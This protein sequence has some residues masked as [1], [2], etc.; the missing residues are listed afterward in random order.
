MKE[1]VFVSIVTL[2]FSGYCLGQESLSLQQCRDLAIKNN[3]E[4]KESADQ[5]IIADQNRKAAFTKYFPNVSANGVYIWNQKDLDLI[6]YGALGI[7]GDIIPQGVRDMTSLDIQNIWIGSLSL[8]QP[9]FMGGKI[10]AYNQ[11]MASAKAIAEN[12]H[13]LSLQNLIYKTDEV[14]WQIVSLANKKELTDDYVRLLAK[15]DNNVNA[16]M[17]EGVAT[18]ADGL[19][20]KVKL[21]EAEMAQ[22]KVANGL[23]L[24]RMLLAQIC[25][26]DLNGSIKLKDEKMDPLKT[27]SEV[28]T[29]VNMNQIY[30]DRLE[31][32][33]LDLLKNIYKK[34]EA[35]ALADELPNLSL[36]ANYLTT[37]PNSFNGYKNKFGG[38]FNVGFILRV[39]LSGWWEGHYKK[40]AAH[41]QRHIAELQ[42]QDTQEKIELQVSQSVYKIK[43]ATKK[44]IASERNQS[45]AEEN[46]RTA[47]YGF[48]EG[49]IPVINMMA[50]Q[51]A[52]MSARSDLIDARIELR[53][54]EVYLMKAK[55]TL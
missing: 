6:D 52:W 36:M 35:I 17:D 15:M 18:K 28:T 8:V 51:T 12:Q 14:Y 7:V 23:A 38:F 5:V 27:I 16:M 42:I 29:E 30:R 44:V 48:K 33:S 25:G 19:S 26:L 50:A 54:A 20:I 1:K 24:S 39:P 55:G 13:N 32:K 47:N 53:L 40:K 2:L 9:V 11:I 43:E 10:I 41:V 3:K 45:K 34:K 4:L 37:N 21:N 46:L 49:V 22:T 31:L